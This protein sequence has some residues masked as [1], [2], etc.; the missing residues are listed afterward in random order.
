[1]ISNP[2]EYL[3]HL[4]DSSVEIK[5]IRNYL[6]PDFEYL[7]QDDYGGDMDCTLTSITAI[8]HYLTKLPVEQIY[9]DTLSI[10]KKYGYTDKKGTNPLVVNCILKQLCKKYSINKKPYS[11]Y[12][13][14]VGW[15]MED[16]LY[17][18]ILNLWDDGYYH[19][20]T[21]T[22]VGQS[23]YSVSGK[24]DKYFIAVADNWSKQVRYI[25]YDNLSRI[26]SINFLGVL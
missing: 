2:E 24:K 4:Y 21:V 18:S 5:L 19:N 17:P 22:I 20:H 12:L 25:D 8:F 9:S 16:L 11:L 14:G 10:A 3:V 6:L 13:K 7:L 1:M 23:V 15:S 26:C